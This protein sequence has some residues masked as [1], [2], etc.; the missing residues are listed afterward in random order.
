MPPSALGTELIATWGTAF[1]TKRHPLSSALSG[2]AARAA[3]RA[4]LD[5]NLPCRSDALSKGHWLAEA[6]H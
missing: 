2:V 5:A 1:A 6:V 4:R 3:Q